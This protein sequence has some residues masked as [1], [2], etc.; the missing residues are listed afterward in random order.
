M[1][2]DLVKMT[3][4]VKLELDSSKVVLPDNYSVANAM[5]AAYLILRDVKDKQGRFA[6]EVCSQDSIYYAVLNMA[7]QGLNPIKD[8]C[9]F[10]AFGSKLACLRGYMGSAMVAKRVKPDIADIR[11]EIIYA[12]DT[13]Q[14]SIIN[15]KKSIKNHEQKIEDMNPDNIIAAYAIAM[16]KDEKVLSTDIMTIGDIERSWKNSHTNVFD[17]KGSLNPNSNHFK[18]KAEMCKKTVIQRL[19]KPI[20]NH[21]NDGVL[22]NAALSTDEETGFEHTVTTEIEENANTKQID[23]KPVP[24]S[25]KTGEVPGMA[26]RGHG[27]VIYDLSKQLKHTKDMMLENISSFTGRRIAKFSELTEQESDNYIEVLE[28]QITSLQEDQPEWV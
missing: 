10:V 4:D 17:D 22:L 3:E 15:G 13:F 11:A 25:D 26:S 7:L 27:Q 1:A 6:L 21:S 14:F 19:C 9:Y 5:K 8:Q 24:E 12:G 18:F 23:F 2:F 16:D 20:I 28:N